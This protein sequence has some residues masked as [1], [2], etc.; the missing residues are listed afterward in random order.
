MN[1]K[2]LLKGIIVS[3]ATLV[4]GYIAIA[5]P[6]NIFDSLSKDGERIFFISELCLYILIG[7]I[8]L[9]FKEH[10]EKQARKEKER[11]ERRI[12]KINDVKENWYNIAA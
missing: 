5:I 8:F 3:V 6:F 12:A 7:C 9:L 1:K 11:H 4:F 2:D 10:K